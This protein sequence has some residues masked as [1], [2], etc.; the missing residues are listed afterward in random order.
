MKIKFTS[1]KVPSSLIPHEEDEIDQTKEIAG[2][3][4]Q[5]LQSLDV[6][7]ITIDDKLL[8]IYSM[9][10]SKLI[11]NITENLYS[12]LYGNK[13][14]KYLSGDISVVLS[15][16]LTYSTL[17]SLYDIKLSSL[18]PFRTVKYLGTI[19]DAVVNLE[20]EKKLAKE[21]GA[22]GGLL[23]INVRGAMSPRAYYIIDKIWKSILN[24]ELVRYPDNYGL[25]SIIT[26]EKESIKESFI[27]I[28]PD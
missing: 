3:I 28:V 17:Y 11:E 2:Y 24:L 22:E 6:I 10:T 18:I 20:E 21:L 9:Y 4:Y 23:F 27:F 19:A 16:A 8:F 1:L 14:Y 15:E 12:Y 25:I 26:R 7:D 5:A 13:G